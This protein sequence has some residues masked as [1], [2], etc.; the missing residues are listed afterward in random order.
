VTLRGDQKKGGGGNSVR[1]GKLTKGDGSQEKDCAI[2]IL[3]VKK[4]KLGSEVTT[5]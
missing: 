4:H 3:R 5:F 1:G 2:L